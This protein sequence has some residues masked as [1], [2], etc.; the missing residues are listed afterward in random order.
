M[1]LLA[2]PG[3]L[4]LAIHCAFLSSL[5]CLSNRPVASRLL[6][7][8]LAAGETTPTREIRHWALARTTHVLTLL[9]YWLMIK[10]I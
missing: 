8:P 10:L 3:P 9:R 7:A 2:Q 1:P 6:A 5:H 4:R